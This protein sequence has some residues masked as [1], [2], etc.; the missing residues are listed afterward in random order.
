M[1]LNT[2][3]HFKATGDIASANR[4]EQLALHS[5]KD[6]DAVRCAHKRSEAIP[7]FHYETRSFSIVQWVHISYVGSDIGQ[8]VKIWAPE[9]SWMASKKL[10]IILVR[11]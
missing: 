2:R 6:L 3:D 7:R 9:Q 11:W 4:F 8:G 10:N 1:C 5:K